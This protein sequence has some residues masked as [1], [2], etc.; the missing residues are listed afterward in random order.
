VNKL[1]YTYSTTR[2]SVRPNI[3]TLHNIHVCYNLIYTD[4]GP[5]IQIGLSPTFN[6]TTN[7]TVVSSSAD[8][9][10]SHT[11]R[12][13]FP[14]SCCNH[15]LVRSTKEAQLLLWLPIVL[16]TSTTYT[17][18]WQTIKPVSVTNLRTADTHDPI[19]RVGLEFMNALI[20]KLYLLKRDHWAWQTIKVQ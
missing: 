11:C 13:H 12:C 8:N 16:R 20:P 4:N 3:S 10:V 5:A 6:Q 19:Q 14:A 15:W 7:F 2:G 1:G 17:V 9:S 18:Y